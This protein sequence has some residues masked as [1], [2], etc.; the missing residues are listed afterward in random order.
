MITRFHNSSLVVLALAL[1]LNY[2]LAAP[3]AL[4]VAT[5]RGGFLIDGAPVEGNATLFDGVRIETRKASSS[6]RLGSGATAGLAGESRARVYQERLVLERGQGEVASSS[7]YRMEALGL[8]IEPSAPGASARVTLHG[9]KAVQVAAVGGPVRVL[10]GAGF[11]VGNVTP[12]RALLFS[13]QAAGAATATTMSGCVTEEDGKYYLTDRT[14]GVK[15]QVRGPIIEQE[16]GNEVDI[17]GTVLAPDH[18]EVNSINRLGTGC[19]GSVIPV[20]AA[21]GVAAGAAAG[22]AAGTTAVVIVGVGVAAAA[23]GYG[24]YRAQDDNGESSSR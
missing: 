21:A 20:A 15:M 16:A 22:M 5:A 10:T 24:S 14:S 17:V 12:S 19:R 7:G 8:R 3:A 11:L 4:G 6:I 13:P 2:S 23:A 9:D 1:T 18:V